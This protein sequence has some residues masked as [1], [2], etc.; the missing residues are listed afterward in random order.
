MLYYKAWLESRMRFLAA[1]TVLSLYCVTF[2]REARV[3]FPPVFEPRLPFT[4]YVWR[5]IYDGVDTLVFILFAAMLGLGGLEREREL[6]SDGF[7]LALPVTRSQLLVP[8]VA[9]AMIEMIALAAIPVV[10][11]PW[12]SASIGRSYPVE[13]AVRF[14][15]L[16][17]VTGG[18]WVS[19]GVLSSV[20]LTGVY[21]SLVASV[22]TPAAFAAVAA[23]SAARRHPAVSPFNV[24]NGARLPIVNR[25]TA[26][27]NGPLPW[28]SL[29]AFI[30]ISAVLLGAAFAVSRRRDF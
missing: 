13:H 10:V 29:C 30:A 7:T 6:G 18:L 16:F 24:M 28:A 8:R 12:A 17:A 11:V 4:A 26:L 19:A 23:T 2:I 9:V 5:G 3:N 27:A 22:L 15:L 1:A 25:V 14:A 21:T 20:L